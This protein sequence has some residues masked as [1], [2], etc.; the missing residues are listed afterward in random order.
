MLSNLKRQMD[1]LAAASRG[2]AFLRQGRSRTSPRAA[3][4]VENCPPQPEG[5][6]GSTASQGTPI[7]PARRAACCISGDDVGKGQAEKA[8]RAMRRVDARAARKRLPAP[9]PTPRA[10]LRVPAWLRLR[11]EIYGLLHS[12]RSL[13]ASRSSGLGAG[14]PMGIACDI[15]SKNELQNGNFK[16]A[17]DVARPSYEGKTFNTAFM[18]RLRAANDTSRW[19]RNHGHS[20]MTMH[21]QGR[22]PAIHVD[23]AAARLLV[24]EA[25]GF[26]SRKISDTH[27][28]C[29]V[30]LRECLITWFEPL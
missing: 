3:V 26:N 23:G 16:A 30:E 20:P 9:P 12:V 7:P 2:L 19:L 29:S 8:A 17:N 14:T 27:R 28:H 13:L 21:L 4:S 22:L 18:A 11:A 6:H 24:T 10:N 15:L 25:H 5:G 1:F